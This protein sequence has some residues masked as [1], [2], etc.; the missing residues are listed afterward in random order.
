MSKVEGIINC[1]NDSQDDLKSIY[2]FGKDKE[3]FKQKYLK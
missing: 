1:Y 3:K 2:L